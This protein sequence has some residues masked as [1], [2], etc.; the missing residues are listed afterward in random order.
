M[1]FAAILDAADTANN[2]I[3]IDRTSAKS[4]AAELLIE[5]AMTKTTARPKVLVIDSYKRLRDN[6]RGPDGTGDVVEPTQECLD[7]LD[8]IKDNKEASKMMGT[9]AILKPISINQFYDPE[10]F[11]VAETYFD[12]EL[13]RPA[14]PGHLLPDGS[15]P[16]RVKWQY[17]YLATFNTSGTHYIILDDPDDCPELGTLGKKGYVVANGQGLMVDRLRQ[18]IQAG[19]PLVMLHNTGGVTQAFASLREG[20]VNSKPLPPT[21]RELLEKHLELVSPAAWAIKFGLPEALMMLELNQRAPMLLRTGCVSVDVMRDESDSVIKTLTVCFAGGDGIPELGLGEAEKLC[22]LTAWKR[23]MTLVANAKKYEKVAD[24]IQMFL[25]A[26]AMVT[27]LLAVLYAQETAANEEAAALA[28]AA[29]DADGT[30]VSTTTAAATALG[31]TMV[32]LP[33]AATAVG[34]VRSKLRPREKWG[35]CLMAAHQI[36][37]QIYKYRLRT[38]RYDTSKLTEKDIKQGIDKKQKEIN[39]RGDFVNMVGE[40]YSKAIST[41]VSKGG[42]LKIPDTFGKCNT[43][44][45]AEQGTFLEE[46]HDHVQDFFFGHEEQLPLRERVLRRR[47]RKARWKKKSSTKSNKMASLSDVMTVGAD[48]VGD[49]MDAAAA[50]AAALFE[51]AEA[52]VPSG[53]QEKAAEKVD[54]LGVSQAGGHDDLFSRI[55]VET[56]IGCRVRPYAEYLER[57]APKVSSRFNYLESA[58]LAANTAGAVLAVLKMADWIA[59]TVAVASVAMALQDYF[60]IPSQLGETNRAVQDVHN[61]LTEVDSLSIVERKKSTVKVKCVTVCEGALLALCS[62]RTQESPALPGEDAGDEEEEGA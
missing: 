46:L 58:A 34:T 41:E 37:D 17:H 32:F 19:E 15:L 4:P 20:I 43:H 18:T 27:T 28:A 16:P 3:L 57:R 21:A 61:L 38:D 5:F 44:K 26:L 51:A 50:G 54:H 7:K 14:E 36:V 2:W 62:A 53:Q 59:I 31:L 11:L 47:Q 8:L 39:A 49:V 48:A 30:A 33:I 52:A 24:G 25:Y 42:A 55:P 23:H 12:M 9:D 10:K 35:S 45:E 40:I 56:Y 1:I 13:P 29:P 6:F 22:I 60:Y